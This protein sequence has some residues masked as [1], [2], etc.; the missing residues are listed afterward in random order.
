MLKLHDSIEN[1]E[2]LLKVMKMLK[3]PV[4]Q[5]P[6]AISAVKKRL[7][8]RSIYDMKLYEYD[9][10]NNMGIF[11]CSVQSGSYVRTMCVHMGLLLGVEGS[12]EELRRV[13]SG[14]MNEK[15]NLYTMHDVMDAQHLYKNTGDDTYLRKIIQPLEVLV[16]EFPRIVV[17]DSA[18]DAICHGAKLLIPGILR[19][20][21]EIQVNKEIVMVT[22]KGEAIALG[23]ALMTPS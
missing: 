21:A 4:F 12:M 15:E 17:K 2:K 23:I 18:V 11:W 3:G 8:V 6:P 13:R 14:I 9:E 10:E 16:K 5:K 7:R 22:S 20:S 19:Y 1:K